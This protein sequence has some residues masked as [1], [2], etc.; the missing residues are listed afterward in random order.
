M[1]DANFLPLLFISYAVGGTCEVLF[2]IIRK[3][4]IAEGLLVT[5]MLYPLILP[6]TIPYWMAALGIAFGVVMGKELFGGTGM[7]ILNPA[8]TGRAFLFFTF[9][10]K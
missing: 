5:G 10:A 3:H 9:P 1:L 2:A 8:L 7:N 6:P 4:K